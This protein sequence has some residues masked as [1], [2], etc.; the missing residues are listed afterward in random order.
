MAGRWIVM[1]KKILCAALAL[2]AL[3]IPRPLRAQG[4]PYTTDG[5]GFIPY[6]IGVG[7]IPLTPEAALGTALDTDL[8][9]GEATAHPQPGDAVT[10]GGRTYHWR[11]VTSREGGPVVDLPQAGFGNAPNVAAYLLSYVVVDKDEDALAL[12]GVG[13]SGELFVNGQLTGR[14]PLS[15]PVKIDDIVSDAIHL[16]K[17]VNTVLVKVVSTSTKWGGVVRLAD[18][19]DYPLQHLTISLSPN[20]VSG[21]GAGA[22]KAVNTGQTAKEGP[23]STYL[24]AS[25]IGYD[26][27]EGKLAIATS[28]RTRTWK[29]IELRDAATDNTVFTIPK[30]GGSIQPMG[31]YPDVNQYISRIYFSPFRTPGRYYLYS[32]DVKVKSMSFNIRED[33]YKTVAREAARMFYFQ[34]S[35]IDRDEKYAG[36]W[37]GPAYHDIEE[38]K[39]AQVA[40]WAGGSWTNIGD[41]ITDPTPRDVEGGWYDAGDPNKYTKNEVSAHNFL[42]MTYDMNKPYLKPGDLNIPESENRAPDL[43]G[44]ARWTTEYLL[45]LQRED[46]AVFDRVAHGR[47]YG[48]HGEPLNPPTRIAEP[49]S[50]ATLCAISAW[51]WAAAIWKE[52]GWDNGFASRCLTA[53]EESWKYMEVHPSPW[54]LDANGKPKNIGS[55]D[56]GYGDENLWRALAAATLFRATGDADCKAIAEEYLSKPG[57][58]ELGYRFVNEMVCHNYMLGVGAD[59]AVVR[60]YADRLSA[61]VKAYR[62]DVLPESKKFAYGATHSNTFHWG[63]NGAVASRTGIMLWWAN[64]FAP[65]E[66]M[67]LYVQAGDEYLQYLLG[68]NPNRFVYMTNMQAVGATRSPQVMFHFENQWPEEPDNLWLTPDAAHPKRT[69]AFPGYLLGGPAENILDFK[70]NPNKPPNDFIRMEPSIMYQAP[71]VLLTTYLADGASPYRK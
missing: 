29:S 2:L 36:K 6:W 17:G 50:G 63:S 16:K 71:L 9:H 65:R 49:S 45:R 48:E 3:S 56:W 37:A 11:L 31:Q 25:Q 20:G 69:G 66:E 39:K 35:G 26:P 47:R 64:Y 28:L 24:V 57:P 32:P 13:G 18:N 68:R 8:L 53:A 27:R 59:S 61:T 43:L 67:P 51:A 14:R 4:N 12:W 58:I 44:E 5:A 23:I 52:G 30:D 40:E 10:I 19:G 34:R 22:W 70:F 42:L 21:S 55:I 1:F 60:S 33:V 38:A 15:G 7:P 41:K 54:P 62:D 46:G